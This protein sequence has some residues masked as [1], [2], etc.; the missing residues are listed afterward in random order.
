MK[1]FEPCQIG[2]MKLRNRL[3]MAPM[4]CNLNED[5]F[6][7]E[8][9]IRFFEERA[10]G[11]VGLI[12]IG[13]GIVDSPVGNNVKE[14]TPID[15]DKYIPFL[16]NLTQAVKVYGAKIAL[17]LSHGGRRAGRISKSGYLDI[18]RGKIPV[19]PS[20]LPHPV[21]GQVVPKELTIEEIKKLVKK[22]REAARRAIEA[23]F[24]AIGLH[25]AHMYLCGQFLS[26]WA[27]QRKDAYG[28]TLE[29]R[30]KFV[31]EIIQ[32][33]KKEAGEQYPLIVR[34]NGEEPE[35]G[36]SIEEIKEIA[37][38][39]EK[40]G[41]N[42]I[43]VSVGFGAPTRDPNLIPSV[44][45]M[46]APDG[47]IV[48]LA[49]NIKRT[50][51]IPVIAVNKILG[52][53]SFA[54]KILQDKK[55]DFIALGRPLIAD[56]YLPK[57]ALEG[58]LEDIRPCI[59][60]CRCIQ[61]V[62]ENDE[63]IACSVNPIAGYE[64]E[65]NNLMP[66]KIKKTILVLGAG[67]SGMTAALTASQKGHRVI[68]VEKNDKLGG[69]LLLAS[70]PP[71][72]SRINLFT[73]YLITK[74]NKA[75][76]IELKIGESFSP[77]MINKFNPNIVILA[78]G[79]RPI[80]PSIPGLT[81]KNF[82][83]GTEVLAGAPVKGEK[84][85]VIG[86]GQVGCEVA[87]FLSEQGKEVTIV[88]IMDSIARNMPHINKISLEMALEQ[89]KVCIMTNTKVISINDKGIEVVHVEERKFLPCDEIVIAAGA[90]PFL[91]KKEESIIKEKVPEVYLIG[92]QKVP[93][94]ILE[95]IRDGFELAKNL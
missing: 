58:R 13:D 44:A 27:N 47:C 16:T 35:G 22:F 53:I 93:N 85:V 24:D 77:E 52:E 89:K 82:L 2:S 92:D 7:K 4:S 5:G 6:V 90:E 17:Q 48:H 8:R 42:S 41:V 63:P 83:T 29:G 11:G 62:L 60:C 57:K 86:G 33:I 70:K 26:P 30:L 46:R 23:G 80:I 38:R 88:E 65:N 87:E 12:I 69:Q 71:G 76:N 10:K 68:L 81:Q 54:E 79:S 94:G 40:A 32:A 21:T 15:D 45:P 78:T 66:A 34:M 25:C 75:H 9:M 1:L 3:V 50:V 95:A 61:K 72:K 18:T 56:P 74:L 31:L 28:Q 91:D 51:S 73:N 64:F 55:A 14:S 39:L 67:P 19:A 49:E 84:V 36:N 20:P 59:Y 43:H 37:R